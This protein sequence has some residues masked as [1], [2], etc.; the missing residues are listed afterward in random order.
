MLCPMPSTSLGTEQVYTEGACEQVNTL[1]QPWRGA[2]DRNGQSSVTQ[3]SGVCWRGRR[4]RLKVQETFLALALTFS[5]VRG[6][7]AGMNKQAGGWP[8][9]A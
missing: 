1:G 3:K 5:E 4:G 8:R 9:D 2:K 6:L 7:S